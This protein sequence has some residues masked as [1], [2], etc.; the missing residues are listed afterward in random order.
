MLSHC[1]NIL[2][3]YN[4]TK[5]YRTII[6]SYN[7]AIVSYRMAIIMPYC[8]VALLLPSYRTVIVQVDGKWPTMRTQTVQRLFLFQPAVQL[9]Q[10]L[11]VSIIFAQLIYWHDPQ[12]FFW[13][14]VPMPD[15]EKGN[16]T[17]SKFG[18]APYEQ[19]CAHWIG[20]SCGL[21]NA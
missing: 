20:T 18:V 3:S 19:Q 13:R 10:D 15:W 4:R 1:H 14:S 2:P 16:S 17:K 9:E 12:T 5:L 7:H 21:S 6:Q 11:V 8:N